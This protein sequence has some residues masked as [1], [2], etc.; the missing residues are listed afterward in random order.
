MTKLNTMTGRTYL[1]PGGRLT[2]HYDPP[3]PCRILTRW[4]PRAPGRRGGPRNVLAEYPGDGSRAVIPFPRRLGRTDKPMA[5]RGAYGYP[6]RMVRPATRAEMARRCVLEPA[7]AGAGAEV[8]VA[9]EAR[10]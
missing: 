10:W 3:R 7:G 2:G 6:P 9:P 5:G 4:A 8:E 1:D